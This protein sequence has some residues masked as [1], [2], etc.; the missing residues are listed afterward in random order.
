MPYEKRL[1]VRQRRGVE[2]DV[3]GECG[4]KED[5]WPGG[6]GNCRYGRLR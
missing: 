1:E 6:V 4:L 5:G 3:R 2:V